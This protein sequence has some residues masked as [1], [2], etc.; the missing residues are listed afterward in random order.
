MGPHHI[1]PRNS[2]SLSRDCHRTIPVEEQWNHF[3]TPSH[4][5]I[6]SFSFSGYN[7]ND[8]DYQNPKL[9]LLWQNL[10]GEES[11]NLPCTMHSAP[12]FPVSVGNDGFCLAIDCH[13]F[14]RFE[15]N[16]LATCIALVS[17]ERKDNFVSN[18]KPWWW[19]GPTAVKGG[20]CQLLAAATSL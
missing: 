18:C 6:S 8:D 17:R 12:Q 14:V 2:P 20:A 13:L 3:P 4:N 10:K 1:F 5:V 16:A 15:C 7:N 11:T 9:A 19:W